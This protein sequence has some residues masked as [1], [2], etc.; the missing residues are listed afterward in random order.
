MVALTSNGDTRI[1]ICITK[2]FIQ[3][4]CSLQHKSITPQLVFAARFIALS[5]I[6]LQYMPAVPFVSHLPHGVI[7]GSTVYYIVLAVYALGIALIFSNKFLQHGAAMVGLSMIASEVLNRTVH[8]NGH[9]YTA[10]MLVLIAL[11]N[12][13]TKNGLLKAQTII[14]YIGAVMNKMVDI[15]WW[16]GNYMHTLMVNRHHINW[17]SYL[18]GFFPVQNFSALAGIIALGIELAIPICF[19]VPRWQKTGFIIALG[20]H[21]ILLIALGVTFGPFYYALFCSFLLFIS[22]PNKLMITMGKENFET[23]WLSYFE[24][25]QTRFS[26]NT[27]RIIVQH[28]PGKRQY[29]GM[30][31][32]IMIAYSTPPLFYI[33]ALLARPSIAPLIIISALIIFLFVQ[34]F[35]C[36]KKQMA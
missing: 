33:L 16:N 5:L 1:R 27:A 30:H 14:L 25:I 4:F 11:S 24:T 22:W 19:I 34:V 10:S 8:S 3:T 21:S 20:F 18:E 7:M 13:I 31:G 9:L 23:K 15:D 2:Y 26:E 28:F 6:G 12:S 17:Y 32:W 35:G 29:I 36:H